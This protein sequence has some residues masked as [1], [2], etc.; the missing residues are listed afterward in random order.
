MDGEFLAEAP[1]V[2]LM[3]LWRQLLSVGRVATASA[4]SLRTAIEAMRKIPN[5]IMPFPEALFVQF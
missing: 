5:V 1:Q 4:C 2:K 3:Q